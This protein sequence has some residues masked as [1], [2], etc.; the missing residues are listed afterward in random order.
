MAELLFFSAIS[1]PSKFKKDLER[2]SHLYAQILC[3]LT[4]PS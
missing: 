3:K 4:K 2:Y 1:D